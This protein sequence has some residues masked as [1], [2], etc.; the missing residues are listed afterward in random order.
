MEVVEDRLPVAVAVAVFVVF[1]V[2]FVVFFVCCFFFY[3][4]STQKFQVHM[5]SC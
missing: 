1:V 2:V 3:L 4:P 5:A